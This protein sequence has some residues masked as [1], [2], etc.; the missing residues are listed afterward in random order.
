[1]ISHRHRVFFA[2]G[3]MAGCTASSLI[4]AGPEAVSSVPNDGV[5]QLAAEVRGMGWIVYGGRSEQGDWDLFACRPD[6][7]ALHPL[8]H[9]PDFSEITPQV[10]RDGR[11]ML[12]RRLKRSEKPDNNRHGEQGELV[13]ANSDGTKPQVLGGEGEF[14]WA[15]WSP[16]GRQFASLSIRG[17][18]IIDVASKQVVRR[19]ERKGFFQQL[20]WSPDGQ[21]LVGVANS[22]GTGWSIARMNVATGAAEAVNRVDCCTPDWFPDS[23]SVIFSWRPP[24]QKANNGYGWTQLWM[25]DAEGKS[26]QLVYG[27]DGRHVYGG[28]VSPDGKYVLFTGNLQEDGDPGNAGA[29][30]GLMR[31]SDAPIIGGESKELRALHPKV[32]N[33]PVLPLPAGWEPCWTFAELGS[34]TPTSG[35][36]QDAPARA[37]SSARLASELHQQGWIAFSSKTGAG[38][39]DL[40]LMRPDG[41]R[42]RRLTDTREF[43][44]AGVRF[45]P[46]GKRLLYYRFPKSEAAENSRYGT[47]DLVIAKADG[48]EPEVYGK[49]YSWASWGPDSRQIACLTKGKGIELVDLA[50]RKVVQRFPSKGL[51]QQ[52]VWSPDGKRF[53][54]TANGLGV[55]WCIGVLNPVSGG[56][57]AVSETDRYNC[58]PDWCPDSEQVV[59]ARGIVPNG[60]GNAE[61]WVASA[62]GQK[63]RR[64]Y[65]EAGMH[66]YGACASPDGKYVMF[67]RS[68]EDVDPVKELEMAII[69]WPEASNSGDARATVRLDLGPGWE[70]HWTAKEIA[71]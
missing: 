63:R 29:P 14:P 62:D 55:A 17:I 59:Y 10:S 49:E 9:T 65:A 13:V 44:E 50:T 58:T 37:D 30:M 28:N 71:Q 60:P 36:S 35:Q 67:T 19:L 22:Y 20:T 2:A 48:T 41:S 21:W 31:L 52:L 25:A 3:L 68:I 54:G 42:R 1:M 16:D 47:F 23:H 26:R 6:G 33:G 40:F 18:A 56:L 7:S 32:N 34:P 11:R 38:D 5:K 69:R 8:T 66:I 27:E 15:S 57:Q 70:P 51:Y 43:S 39:W 4:G 61:L 12:Y 64:I 53:V 24:G 46:D 45:S